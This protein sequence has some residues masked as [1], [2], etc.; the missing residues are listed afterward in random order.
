MIPVDDMKML[1]RPILQYHNRNQGQDPVAPEY[2][3]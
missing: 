3:A 1:M 2:N